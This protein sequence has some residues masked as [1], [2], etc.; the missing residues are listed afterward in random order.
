MNICIINPPCRE[1]Q[2]PQVPLGLIY[3]AQSLIDAG[4]SI[5]FIDVNLN[6]NSEEEVI[7]RAQD[8]EILLIGGLATTYSYL[9]R[10]TNS[11]NKLYPDVPIMA[12][13]YIAT[14]IPHVIFKNTGVTHIC[15]GEGDITVREYVSA[16]ESSSDLL[17]VPGLFIKKNDSFIKTDDRPLIKNLDEIN[18]PFDAYKLLDIEK[19][20]NG[21]EQNAKLYLNP[22]DEFLKKG[23]FRL[24]PILSGRGCSAK[25]TFCY[26]M[27]PGM[28]KH[29]VPYVI[30]HMKYLIDTYHTNMF[31]FNDEL[32]VGNKI[33]L[34]D[35]CRAI[36]DSDIDTRFS[37]NARAN[38][39][40]EEMISMLKKV[41]CCDIQIGI[42][43]GSQKI[44]DAMNKN[45]KVEQNYSAYALLKKYGFREAGSTVFG[46]PGE[47][48]N[49]FKENLQ[50]IK[51]CELESPSWYYATPYPKSELY[52]YAIQNGYIKDE[53]KYLEEI[54]NCDASEFKIN[55]TDF[56]DDEL[57]FYHWFLIDECKKNR[58]I[59][60]I[61][62]GNASIIQL[63]RHRL[64]HGL[65]KYL[66]N[67]R[68]FGL[69]SKSRD[70]LHNTIKSRKMK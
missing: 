14:P 63:Y 18:P 39:I 62:S 2:A 36:A 38:L 54:S 7:S 17:K 20:I 24:L 59:H 66:F 65:V 56:S 30:N 9:K 61:K 3:V 33:W 40:S 60:E 64:N 21:M 12:G 67:L 11:I 25:C 19:Y 34:N 29:S 26:R 13:G 50:L 15:I 52:Q 22:K 70:V 23:P 37:I 10:I 28:R 48:I 8:C 42:E 46:M 45:I 44:L 69:V 41:G 58:I 31:M 1:Y 16:I 35:F 55:F 68:L 57:R 53:E 6:K 47:D 27:I 49:T 43:S 32:F 51:N 5:D 4:H